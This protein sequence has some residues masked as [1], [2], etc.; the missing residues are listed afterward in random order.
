MPPNTDL[1][2]AL[3]LLRV[4]RVARDVREVRELHVEAAELRQDARTSARPAEV[5]GGL[6]LQNSIFPFIRQNKAN[7]ASDLNSVFR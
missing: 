2:H 5:L 6:Q 3:H 4:H 7:S 1:A